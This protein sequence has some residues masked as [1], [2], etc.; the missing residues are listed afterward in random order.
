MASSELKTLREQYEAAE[1]HNRIALLRTETDL[2]T[3]YHR[4]E[5]GEGRMLESWGDIVPPEEYPSHDPWNWNGSLGGMSTLGAGLG[6]RSRGRN[7]PAVKT[8]T[9]LTAIRAM[10]RVL[11][12]SSGTA[13]CVLNNLA[14]YILG[15]GCKYKVVSGSGEMAPPNLLATAQAVVNDFLRESKWSLQ[16]EEDLFRRSRRDGEWFLALY[17]QSGGKV[18]SRVIEP[19]QV[20]Q[21]VDD[22]EWETCLPQDRPVDWT[23]GI[24]TDDDDMEQV[25]GYNVQWRNGERETRRFFSASRIVH[26]KLNVDSN[27]KRGLSDFYPVWEQLVDASKLLR[28]TAKGAAILSAIAMIRQHAPGVSQTQIESMRAGSAFSRFTQQTK[29]GSR[30]RYTHHY[31]PGTIVDVPKGQEYKPSPLAEQGAGQSMVVIEQAVL[32][33]AGGNWCMPEYMIS[34]DVG[35]AAYAS[36]LVAE[37]PFVK[38]CQRQ[39]KIY[40]FHFAEVLWKVLRIAYDSGRFDRLNVSWEDLQ[41]LL[42]INIDAPIVAARDLNVETNRRKIL[43]DGGVLSL[44][45]WAAEEG[46]DY[47][48]EKKRG[49]KKPEPPPSPFGGPSPFG[50]KKPGDQPGQPVE[51]QGQQAWQGTQKPA[52]ERATYQ[53]ESRLTEAAKLLWGGYPAASSGIIEGVASDA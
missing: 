28:N 18:A 11:A 22:R 47:E 6:D 36:A 15:T 38:Y 43:S 45:T 24:A 25:H 10:S 5:F 21:P 30:T 39:Q 12:D 14:S 29:E 48:Q 8:E 9:D 13:K 51:D 26:C 49:A 2:L 1:L 32:R 40:K 35:N 23:F 20:L 27:I 41:A 17:K 19:E 3:G 37:S 33:I 16:R 42:D 50:Q 31:A 53:S 44:E 52:P 7:Q 34:G 4:D 46:Y